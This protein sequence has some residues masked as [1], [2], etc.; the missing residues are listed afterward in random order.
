MPHY[1]FVLG[2]KFTNSYL[3]TLEDALKIGD[4][5]AASAMGY[6]EV[7]TVLSKQ[8]EN[9]NAGAASGKWQ[10]ILPTRPWYVQYQF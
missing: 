1:H 10:F 8:L 3:T 2:G 6:L 7:Q 5:S 4:N 9:E